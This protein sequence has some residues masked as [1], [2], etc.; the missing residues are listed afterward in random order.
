MVVGASMR[1]FLGG[2]HHQSM[3]LYYGRP[4]QRSAEAIEWRLPLVLPFS[5][6]LAPQCFETFSTASVKLRKTQREQ[7]SSQ[8]PLKADIPH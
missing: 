2:S 5:E 6:K 7:M 3:N 4:R 8:L 1:K